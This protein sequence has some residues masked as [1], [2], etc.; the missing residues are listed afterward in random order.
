MSF[1]FNKGRGHVITKVNVSEVGSGASTLIDH[2]PFMVD[3]VDL[4]VFILNE[5]KSINMK[6]KGKV[7][8]EFNRSF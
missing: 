3:H 8:W 4:L 6:K 1:N 7:E 2:N 5:R